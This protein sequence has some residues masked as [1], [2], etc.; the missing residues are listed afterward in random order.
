MDPQQ[1]PAYGRN[2]ENLKKSTIS[3]QCAD[4]CRDR[5]TGGQ[6]AVKKVHQEGDTSL[7]K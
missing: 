5:G 6:K 2:A 4:P 7:T 1:C 3:R